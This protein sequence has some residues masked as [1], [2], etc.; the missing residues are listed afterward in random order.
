MILRHLWLRL[1]TLRL[2]FEVKVAVS[3]LPVGPV[4]CSA[5][6]ICSSHFVVLFSGEAF[7]GFDV[8]RL[9]ELVVLLIDKVHHLCGLLWLFKRFSLVSAVAPHELRLGFVLALI[10]HIVGSV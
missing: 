8:V 7:H 1:Q 3:V 5:A 6:A 10:V 2:I 4:R 9:A